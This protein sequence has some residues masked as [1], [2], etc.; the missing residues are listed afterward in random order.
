M[1]FI[2]FV[3]ERNTPINK[4]TIS[5]AVGKK[6]VFEQTKRIVFEQT[7]RNFGRPHH[8]LLCYPC[9]IKTYLFS[10]TYY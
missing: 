7:K 5:V 6:T 2:L 4:Q 3:H 1:A 9:L 10:K 8:R